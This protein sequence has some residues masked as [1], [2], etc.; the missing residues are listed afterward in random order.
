MSGPKLVLSIFLI[1][2]FS[3]GGLFG[4]Y[5]YLNRTTTLEQAPIAPAEPTFSGFDQVAIDN[6]NNNPTKTVDLVRTSE[7][8]QLEPQR[9]LLL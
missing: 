7:Q 4:F 2:I 8:L 6:T 3:I 9:Q 5:F 1:I